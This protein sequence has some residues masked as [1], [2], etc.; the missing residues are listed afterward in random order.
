MQHRH[1]SN[2]TSNGKKSKRRQS[3][4]AALGRHISEVYFYFH[5]ILCYSSFLYTS[6]GSKFDI[7]I[8]WLRSAEGQY[9]NYL[10]SIRVPYLTIKFHGLR[11]VSSRGEDF[12]WF[13]YI[14]ARRPCC[15]IHHSSLNYFLSPTRRILHKL[16]K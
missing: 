13:Y 2:E 1:N 4:S 10:V 11:S 7:A 15:L 12:K 3:R 8:K 5:E 16:A 9:L 6:T 14:L